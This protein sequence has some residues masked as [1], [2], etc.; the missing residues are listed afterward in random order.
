[1]QTDEI[2][3]LINKCKDSDLLVQLGE[4]NIDIPD[5]IEV[6]G[7]NLDS[8]FIQLLRYTNGCRVGSV[9]VYGIKNAVN[10]IA[11]QNSSAREI[12]D[13][14]KFYNQLLL[15]AGIGYQATEL[16]T[17]P[18]KAN[19]NGQH[20]VVIVDT[21]EEPFVLPIAS[22]LSRALY[23]V[24]KREQRLALEEFNDEPFPYD[25]ISEIREDKELI[26]MLATDSFANLDGPSAE[27]NEWVSLLMGH[28]L[29]G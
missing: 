9:Y 28:E 17:V 1:M 18:E 24:F 11:S 10:N 15:F 25:V 19:P 14:I 22:S 12:N 21:N 7:M 26:K 20:P 8:Q 27:F 6:L 4:T 23:L 3:D 5:N 29:V 13:D 2:I 16:A